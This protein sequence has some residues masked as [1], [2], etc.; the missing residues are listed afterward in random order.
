MFALF[1]LNSYKNMK[2]R[3]LLCL[4][5]ILDLSFILSGFSFTDTTNSRESREREKAILIPL[6]L[7]HPL[8]N[9][10]TFIYNFESETTTTYF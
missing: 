1:S 7:L 8:I 3:K 6:Y 4:M 5:N 10:Q 9:F 2:H